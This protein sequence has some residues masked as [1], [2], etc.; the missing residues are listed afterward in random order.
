MKCPN[1]NSEIPGLAIFKVS[2]WSAIECKACRT[3]CNRKV[4]FQ[5]FAVV[6]VG[7]FSSIFIPIAVL[8]FTESFILCALSF[9]LAIVAAIIFDVKTIKLHKAEKRKGFSKILG[10]KI[11]DNNEQ[12]SKST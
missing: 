12:S 9:V 1:C 4:D 2:R 8:V 11:I 7:V 6:M 3:L 5:F 10:Q